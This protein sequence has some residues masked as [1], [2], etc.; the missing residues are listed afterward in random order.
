MTIKNFSS[1]KKL[2]KW[3]QPRKYTE[4]ELVCPTE[5]SDSDHW[6]CDIFF[7]F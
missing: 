3:V 6:F 1:E 2:N 4:D 7:I 5:I